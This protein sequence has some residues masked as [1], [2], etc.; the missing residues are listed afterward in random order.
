[1]AADK[2]KL[3][4]IKKLLKDIDS[5]YSN[6]GKK[7]PFEID[8]NNIKNADKTLE[9]LETVLEGVTHQSELI[10][11]SFGDLV[12]IL[13]NVQNEM[14]KASSHSD[15]MEKNRAK[16]GNA[17]NKNLKSLTDQAQKLK[18][19]EQGYGVESKKSIENI[20]K[21]A[22]EQKAFAMDN[23][24][25]ALEGIK[26]DE[27]SNRF[28]D[29]ETGKFVKLTEAQKTASA[30][31]A[32]EGALMD[33]TIQKMQKR[34]DLEGDFSKELGFGTKA[35]GGLDKAMQ[36]AGLPAL[37]INDAIEKTRK[38]FIE[39]KN[40]GGE[41]AK[42]FKV[43]GDLAK[44]LAANM[45]NVLTTA[46]LLQMAV[47]AFI[48]AFKK[49]D[50]EIGDFAK[51]MGTSYED[52]RALR[53]EMS[54]IAI[55]TGD[56]A[57]NSSLM[58]E[59]QTKMNAQFGSAVKF[60]GQMAKDF[61]SIQK[62]TQL[63]DEAMG[64]FTESSMRTGRGL[65][66]NLKSVTKTVFEMN[67]QKGL[68][69]SVKQVQESIAKTSKSLQLTFKMNTTELAKQ[70]MQVKAMG[71]DMATAQKIASSML[72]FE[73]S[74]AA[75]LSAELLLGKEIN[76]EK[77]RQFALQGDMGKMA[78]EV[79]KN[80]AIMEAFATKNVIAQEAAAKALGLGK[81][82]LANMINEQQ[83]LE[84]LR[85]AGFEDI[86]AAQK[87]Y[88][89]LRDQGLSAE[90]AANELGVE[91]LMGQLESQSVQEKMADATARLQEIFLSLAEVVLPAVQA[92]LSP[93]LFIIE[94][95]VAGIGMFINGLKEGNPLALALAGVLGLMALPAII[96]A[97]SFIFT[98]FAQIPFG[99][100]IPLAIATVAGLMSKLSQGEAKAKKAGDMMSPSG[101]KTQVSTKEGGL[102]EL[103]PNDDLV[104]APG[105]ADRM[106]NGGGNQ[107]NIAPLVA[108]VEQLITI[109]KAILAKSPV[110]EMGGNE[111]GQGINT[112][113]REIQ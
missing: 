72:D 5:Q 73:S 59:A 9:H 85:K 48:S 103:S 77:A 111:V 51:N 35:L 81:D 71:A 18:N 15:R 65:Q 39:A 61:A 40:A 113:E 30:V 107:M 26:F 76:I 32:E 90:A 33:A 86:N 89:D 83:K 47:V 106:K 46:N 50:K 66:A 70:V 27:K 37:G 100:G 52:A 10:N 64:F 94:A 28:R 93:I 110:I 6:I 23:A 97:I 31:L 96:S 21:K 87:E 98:T 54:E 53:S 3:E 12:T 41:Q 45:G 43:S 109:N 8:L 75:E 79:M 74:I 57:V 63:S 2:N 101:G 68:H 42:N 19:E 36:K 17:L 108:K 58:L 16:A 105:A 24:K 14:T 7:R 11:S 92:V 69:M 102:F 38:N 4:E 20:I 55:M 67:K 22:K 112:A 44:N 60:S 91:G 80:E 82:E 78:E 49:A 34:L 95:M 84:D 99:V 104:A 56:S 62:R 13:K 88:N 29:E 25:A 1:M